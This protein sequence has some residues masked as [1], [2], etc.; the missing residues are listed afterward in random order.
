VVHQE[1]LNV[2]YFFP[3]RQQNDRQVKSPGLDAFFE[4]RAISHEY[5]ELQEWELGGKAI[6]SQVVV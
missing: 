4:G 3:G 5:V 1:R 6:E 2:E